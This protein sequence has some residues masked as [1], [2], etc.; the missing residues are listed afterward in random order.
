MTEEIYNLEK[1]NIITTRQLG[2]IDCKESIRRL[3]E[4]EKRVTRLTI[5]AV[6]RDK[7]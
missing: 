5:G 3:V 2:L 7:L 4:L 6:K 1:N